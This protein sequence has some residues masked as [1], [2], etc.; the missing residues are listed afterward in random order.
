MEELLNQIKDND[1]LKHL[2]AMAGKVQRN[3]VLLSDL[4]PNERT[5]D[6]LEDLGV[7]VE[8]LKLLDVAIILTMGTFDLFHVGHA[9]YIRKARQSGAF[10]IVGVDDDEKARGRKGENRPSVPYEERA[11]LLGYLRHVD[12]IVKKANDNA[13]WEMIKVVKPSILIAVKGT[14]TDE[15]LG[16]LTEFCGKVIVL[17]RQAETSTSAKIRRMVLDGADIFRQAMNDM[18]PGFVSSVYEKMR[19]E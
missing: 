16:L 6:N 2:L 7:I 4:D 18:L 10:L 15:D 9:R 5:I 3:S 12:L 19:K 8:F 13:K 1:R 17:D 14:Y 11:E